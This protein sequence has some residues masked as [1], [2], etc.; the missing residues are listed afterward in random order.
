MR[1]T[2]SIAHRGGAALWPENTV[3]AFASAAKSGFDGAE[4]DV[5]L[6]R[7]GKLVVFHDF[8]L[9]PDLCRDS[10]GKWLASG[11]ELPAIANLTLGELQRFDVGRP[12][13][14]SRYA[15]THPELHPRDG[16]HIPSLSQ[17][18]SA[19]QPLENF[20]LFVELKTSLE[21][22]SLTA[23][24]ELLA[25]AVV[26]ELRVHEFVA[27]TVLV[28]FDWRGLVHAKRIAPEAVCWFTTRPRSRFRAADVQAG[29]GEGWF[30]ALDDASA[31]AVA[32]ARA[33]GLAFGVWTV[34]EVTQM[35]RL[36]GLGVDAICTDRPDRLR[37]SS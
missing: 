17:V 31:E 34:N 23:A 36:I 6:T 10:T 21:D 9:N 35:Q 12:K 1:Q 22:P 32:D 25:E 26:A 18:I 15:I 30:C 7:D 24:P 28:G 3:F 20:R 16:E 8:R 14:N 29:G 33:R 27:R 19:V 2:L 4:L 5:Q 37:K 13:P 11:P